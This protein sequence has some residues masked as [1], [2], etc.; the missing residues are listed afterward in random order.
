MLLAVLAA[1]VTVAG[2]TVGVDHRLHGHF[3]PPWLVR[4]M[5][6]GDPVVTTGALVVL[7]VA[8]A[9]MRRWETA[10]RAIIATGLTFGL[11]LAGKALIHHPSGLLGWTL[12]FGWHAVGSL[13]SGH[14][15]RLCLLAAWVSASAPRPVALLV[16]LLALIG[17]VG[18]VA[19]GWHWC[20][21]VVCGAPLGAALGI[22]SVAPGFHSKKTLPEDG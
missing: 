18:L 19:D 3:G 9:V 11:E 15:A 21:D 22:W 4:I 2:L 17:C 1:G 6:L 7:L 5:H 8:T 10:S 13:P 12:P 14:A 20:S 16:W